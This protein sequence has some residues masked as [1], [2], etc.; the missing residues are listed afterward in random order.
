MDSS[1]TDT[2]DPRWEDNEGGN[3]GGIYRRSCW[4]GLLEIYLESPLFVNELEIERKQLEV[5]RRCIAFFGRI[6]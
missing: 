3:P 6:L 2:R 1:K 4:M 5:I